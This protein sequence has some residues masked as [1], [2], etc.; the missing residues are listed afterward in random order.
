M[1]AATLDS[2]FTVTAQKAQLGARPR[3]RGIGQAE[4]AYM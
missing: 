4:Q 3:V 1:S 2:F